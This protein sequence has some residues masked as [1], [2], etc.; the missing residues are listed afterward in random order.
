LD[1]TKHT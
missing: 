1:S